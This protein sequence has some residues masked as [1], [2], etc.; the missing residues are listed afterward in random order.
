VFDAALPPATAA[1]GGGGGAI[2]GLLRSIVAAEL[3][4]LRQACTSV[5]AV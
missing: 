4:V 1:A 3:C 5:R 2:E